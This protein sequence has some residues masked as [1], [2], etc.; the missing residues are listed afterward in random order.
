MTWKLGD[1]KVT[2]IHFESPGTGFLLI[3]KSDLG[4][5]FKYFLNFHPDP[6]GR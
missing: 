4:G 3:S 5:G 6:W 2:L 1:E